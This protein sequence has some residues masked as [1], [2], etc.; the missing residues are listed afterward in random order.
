MI[1]KVIDPISIRFCLFCCVCVRVFVCVC[2]YTLWAV[3]AAGC[4]NLLWYIELLLFVVVA[5][6]LKMK[7]GGIFFFLRLSWECKGLPWILF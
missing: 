2:V 4:L 1:I 5:E 3:E 6:L 7:A